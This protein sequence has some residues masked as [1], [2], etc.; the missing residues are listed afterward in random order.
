MTGFA[1][2][3]DPGKSGAA[4]DRR[5]KSDLVSI[6]NPLIPLG[7]MLVHGRDHTDF[8]LGEIGKAAREVLEGHTDFG[9]IRKLD[10]LLRAASRL[11]QN[12]EKQHL[13]PHTPSVTDGYSRKRVAGP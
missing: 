13:D 2:L 1:I 7:E 12:P 11:L 3:D 6:S 9:A 10:L 8:R 5:Q 4:A